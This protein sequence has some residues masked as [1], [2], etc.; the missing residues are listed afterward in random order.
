MNSLQAA[1]LDIRGH[2]TSFHGIVIRGSREF[3]ARTEGALKILQNTS[4]FDFVK[5]YLSAITQAVTKS[6]G[7][8]PF[9]KK[10]TLYVAS[11]SCNQS[12][13]LY[14]CAIAHEAMRSKIFG[15]AAAK[16]WLKSRVK[17]AE[18]AGPE[19]EKI[20]LGFQLQVLSELRTLNRS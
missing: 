19:A 11:D 18:W 9:G 4:H 20:C 6:G 17:L 1:G 10:C 3:Q 12:P 8:D 13:I 2:W 15:Q 7:L 5:S 14:A 16:R